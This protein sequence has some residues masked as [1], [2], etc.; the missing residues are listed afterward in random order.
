MAP[1]TMAGVPGGDGHAAEGGVVE[2]HAPT[3][4]RPLRH[5]D[6]APQASPSA[7]PGEELV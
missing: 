6:A 3:K 1:A 4:Q 7:F 2:A 5:S